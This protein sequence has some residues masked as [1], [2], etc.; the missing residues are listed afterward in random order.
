[1]GAVVVRGMDWRVSSAHPTCWDCSEV[2]DSFVGPN[3]YLVLLR[4]SLS[5]LAEA[6][7]SSED[8]GEVSGDLKVPD[9]EI[10]VVPR[11]LKN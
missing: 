6:S 8:D 1:M 7:F 9:D 4:A 2:E 3:S 10:K 5:V 11:E